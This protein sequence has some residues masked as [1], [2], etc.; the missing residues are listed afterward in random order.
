MTLDGRRTG[1]E[2][3]RDFYVAF[4][5]WERPLTFTVPPAPSGGIWR[6]VVDTSLPSPQDILPG[7]TGPE[8]AAWRGYRVGPFSLVVFASDPQ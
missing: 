7:L 8:V 3:D 2:S 6:R 5:A 1:W 4:N